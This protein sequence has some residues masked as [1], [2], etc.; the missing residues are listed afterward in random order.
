MLGWK[1]FE[2][3]VYHRFSLPEHVPED[4]PLRRVAAV[5]D[6]SVVRRLTA[7]DK[8]PVLAHC[9]IRLGSR[10]GE[11]ARCAHRTAPGRCRHL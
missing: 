4:H 5:V 11:R 8:I 2:P 7:R 1:T 6:F 9:A 3:K 10:E